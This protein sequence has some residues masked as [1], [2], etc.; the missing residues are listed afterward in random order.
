M[1]TINMTSLLQE[2]EN[3]DLVRIEAAANIGE[4]GRT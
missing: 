1:A 4:G 3:S 2:I